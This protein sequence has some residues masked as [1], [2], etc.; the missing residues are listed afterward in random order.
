MALREMVAT[1]AKVAATFGCGG[2]EPSDALAL[3]CIEPESSRAVSPSFRAPSPAPSPD[4]CVFSRL[5]GPRPA[6]R[7]R[8]A[9]S[10]SPEYD[11]LSRPARALAA[12]QPTTVADS[13][14]ATKGRKRGEAT[15]PASSQVPGK[16]S[17]KPPVAAA[18]FAASAKD[19]ALVLS[20]LSASEHFSVQHVTVVKDDG[21]ILVGRRPR[22]QKRSLAL[23]GAKVALEKADG[24]PAVS[25]LVQG[26]QSPALFCFQN[27]PEARMW[28]AE[29]QSASATHGP[30]SLLE[31]PPSVDSTA[32]CTS[33]ERP[34]DDIDIDDI[35]DTVPAQLDSDEDACEVEE[36]FEVVEAFAME[37]ALANQDAVAVEVAL[38]GKDASVVE[39]VSVVEDASLVE[40]ASV[41][42]EAFE[43]DEAF[44]V[45]ETY[46]EE[47]ADVKQEA[48]LDVCDE[49]PPP[50]RTLSKDVAAAQDAVRWATAAANAVA[51]ASGKD[52]VAGGDFRG[53]LLEPGRAI[54]AS[55]GLSGPADHGAERLAGQLERIAGVFAAAAEQTRRPSPDILEADDAAR[56]N[57]A[58]EADS[59]AQLLR[60]PQ[61]ESAADVEAAAD[62]MLRYLRAAYADKDCCAEVLNET[63]MASPRMSSPR[64]MT[65]PLEDSWD[66]PPAEVNE[67]EEVSLG[68]YDEGRQTS[69]A[70]DAADTEPPLEAELDTDSHLALAAF[71]EDTFAEMAPHDDSRDELVGAFVVEESQ[72]GFGKVVP[73]GSSDWAA[74]VPQLESRLSAEG[75]PSLE[76]GSRTRFL[77][78]CFGDVQDASPAIAPSVAESPE[79]LVAGGVGAEPEGE[80]RRLVG[81]QDLF[82]PESNNVSAAPLEV[83]VVQSANRS[84]VVQAANRSAAAE[85][86]LV[87]AQRQVAKQLA[88]LSRL[89]TVADQAEHAL[90][91]GGEDEENV[92]LRKECD[93]LRS[94]LSVLRHH[95]SAQAASFVQLI[96]KAPPSTGYRCKTSGQTFAP[97]HLAS[98]ASE[99]PPAQPLSPRD[100]SS[101]PSLAAPTAPALARRGEFSAILAAAGRPPSPSAPER[102]PF[103]PRR[104]LSPSSV[105]SPLVPR[106]CAAGPGC[107]ESLPAPAIVSKPMAFAPGMGASAEVCPAPPHQYARHGMGPSAAAGAGSCSAPSLAA[108]YA[109]MTLGSQ[110]GGSTS[111]RSLASFRP[112][113]PP[114]LRGSARC[115]VGRPLPVTVAT[116]ASA[117]RAVSPVPQF[118]GCPAKAAPPARPSSPL[119][120]A[121]LTVRPSSPPLPA[122]LA[123][124]PA[125]P[126]VARRPGVGGQQ[127]PGLRSS[128]PPPSVPFRPPA[129][130]AAS[131]GALRHG[132]E[133]PS[134]FGRSPL[135]PLRASPSERVPTTPRAA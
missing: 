109:S 78:A 108:A 51:A 31:L 35:G 63:Q 104:A 77:S 49:Q 58:A 76:P 18:S 100:R 37:E 114:P 13:S 126:P 130:G 17:A 44:V 48:T 55:Q 84:Q 26:A 86:S 21:L 67:D 29:V 131:P 120:P 80:S 94:Q 115:P 14:V 135:R 102:A 64:G 116:V 98:A 97:A 20:R 12:A 33:E 25:V 121:S 9:R 93:D 66:G 83:A 8:K 36:V 132:M 111:S 3:Q 117:P 90:L 41:A 2:D 85:P 87:Q 110:S 7:R 133:A 106:R 118:A 101:T 89:L 103:T 119:P 23:R 47:N 5:A 38:V 134:E 60:I 50:R 91:H 127:L 4:L 28:F 45:E 53:A 125:S 92:D 75:V 27:Y 59:L 32:A 52:I 112:A 69:E 72:E 54:R 1:K 34:E 105:A 57:I 70:T 46:M 129:L 71:V 113:S 19:A 95:V 107:L 79:V 10:P 128:S 88:D 82:L 40:D 68:G 24:N 30:S 74:Q 61:V 73:N 42:E 123:A 43:V 16:A 81:L 96:D 39:N 22:G 65:A 11:P 15:S 122:L 124:R 99:L 6:P 56:L 62:A